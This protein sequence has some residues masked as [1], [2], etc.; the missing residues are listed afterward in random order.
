M[1]HKRLIN[2]IAMVAILSLLIAACGGDDDE[3]PTPTSPSAGGPPTATPTPGDDGD[4]GDEEP[5]NGEDDEDENGDGMAAAGE[6]I[7]NSQCASCHTTDGSQMTGPTWQ[8]LWGSERTLEDGSTVT[9]DEE[10]IAE[11]IREPDAKI[12]EG[13]GEGIMPAFDLSDEEIEQVIAFMQTVE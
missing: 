8:G 6:E 5:S 4:N 7:Y 11:S 10:Y 12:V 13:F 3:D 2:L 9:A 1:T